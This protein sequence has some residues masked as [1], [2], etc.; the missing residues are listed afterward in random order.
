[1]EQPQNALQQEPRNWKNAETTPQFP[2]VLF[3][4][5]QIPRF[6][7]IFAGGRISVIQ[8]LNV[9]LIGLLESQGLSSCP[10]CWKTQTEIKSGR[11]WCYSSIR[12]SE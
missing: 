10:Q 3:I 11:L 7:T 4:I 2:I 1:M 12:M 5:F 9:L 6:Q 8:E